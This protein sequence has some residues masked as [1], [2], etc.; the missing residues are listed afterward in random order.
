MIEGNVH[1]KESVTKTLTAVIGLAAL[2]AFAAWQFCLFA[3]FK[4]ADGVVDVQGGTVHLWLAIGTALVVCIAGFFLFS[5]FLRYDKRN[6]IHIT[7]PGQ[8]PSDGRIR[9]DIL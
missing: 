6:E 7:S 9:R 3:V 1:H 2:G 4:G 5:R 8:A